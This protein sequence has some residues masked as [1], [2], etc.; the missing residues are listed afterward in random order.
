MKVWLLS[1]FQ[2]VHLHNLNMQKL[3]ILIHAIVVV[4][5]FP[6]YIGM[7]LSLLCMVGGSLL[8]YKIHPEAKAGNCWSFALARWV[9]YGGYLAIR[10]AGDVWFMRVLPIL[11]CLWIQ[12]LGP[13]ELQMTMPRKRMRGFMAKWFP[14]KTP[15]FKFKVVSFDAPQPPAKDSTK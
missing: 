15:Y 13:S 8:A 1:L 10:P 9:K 12:Q 11:H 2:Q 7:S 14:W 3:R 4:L 5:S 6:F